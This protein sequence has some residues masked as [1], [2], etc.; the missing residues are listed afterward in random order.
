MKRHKFLTSI[1]EH[2]V[3]NDYDSLLKKGYVEEEYYVRKYRNFGKG[4]LY[5][6]M[7]NKCKYYSI[8]SGWTSHQ[9]TSKI[10]YESGRTIYG[11][12]YKVRR[13]YKLT[14]EGAA[15]IRGLVVEQ[16]I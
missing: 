10:D 6:L 12:T 15:Y 16:N 14:N 5:V 11:R 9:R 7:E 8:A 13:M 4:N 2:V 3:Y 1:R